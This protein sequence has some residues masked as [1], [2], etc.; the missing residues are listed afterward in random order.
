MLNMTCRTYET[1]QKK[2]ETYRYC[3]ET[4]RIGTDW[5]GAKRS[6]TES[7]VHLKGTERN[8]TELIRKGTV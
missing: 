2:T 7:P 3:L 6:E 1:E 4:E 8:G 5:K